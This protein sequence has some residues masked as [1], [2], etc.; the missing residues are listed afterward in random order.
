MASSDSSGSNGE[1]DEATDAA[2]R[3]GRDQLDIKLETTYTGKAMAG[4]LN[5]LDDANLADKKF[6]FWNTY[7]SAELPVPDDKPLDESALPD[8][9]MRYF[10]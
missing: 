2:V 10:E 5:D 3:F 1:S 7:S 4:L 6:L 9:F 8:E